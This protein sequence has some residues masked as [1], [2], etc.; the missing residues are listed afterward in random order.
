MLKLRKLHSQQDV[1]KTTSEVD[2]LPKMLDLIRMI[3]YNVFLS[4][5][6][7][8]Y[9]SDV[10]LSWTRFYASFK[11]Q[12]NCWV[13]GQLP[14]SSPSGLPW[15]ISPLQGSNWMA[16]RT[17]ILQER[18]FSPIQVTLFFFLINVFIYLFLSVLGLHC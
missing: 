8:A 13:C 10:F 16:L 14:V 1:K 18:K 7:L 4:S 15:W 9:K 12:S 3:I 17:F 11:N 2:S 5:R 6:T